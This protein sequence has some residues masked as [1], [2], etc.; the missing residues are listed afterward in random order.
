MSVQGIVHSG[1]CAVGEMSG[2]GIILSKNCPG[3][4]NCPVRDLSGRGIVCQEI[5]QS[6]NC[7]DI[8]SMS[9]TES[10]SSII[11]NAAMNQLIH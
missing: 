9:S 5:V 11:S 8:M 1:N 4:G 6:G 7:P 3:Q 2:Q 10:S